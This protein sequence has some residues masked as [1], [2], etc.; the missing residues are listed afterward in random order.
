MCGLAGFNG[1]KIRILP[2]MMSFSFKQNTPFF[3]FHAN[4]LYIYT[5][6]IYILCI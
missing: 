4:I 1:K 6:N 5:I 2:R 3:L